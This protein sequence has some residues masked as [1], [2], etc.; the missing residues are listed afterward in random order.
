[1][2]WAVERCVSSC[3]SDPDL[4]ALAEQARSQARLDGPTIGSHL[5]ARVG[6][7]PGKIFA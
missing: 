7:R 1:M 6:D 2:V 3:A 4:A 5:P